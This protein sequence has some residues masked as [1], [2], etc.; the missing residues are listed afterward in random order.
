MIK[1]KFDKEELR[2]IIRD[3]SEYKYRVSHTS[4][5]ES[6]ELLDKVLDY[7]IELEEYYE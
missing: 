3:F 5:D 4:S 7:L 1:D 6:M 2:E